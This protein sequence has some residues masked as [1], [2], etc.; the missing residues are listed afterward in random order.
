MR[1]GFSIRWHQGDAEG[2]TD[3]IPLDWFAIEGPGSEQSHMVTGPRGGKY[4]LARCNVIVRALEADLDYTAY[5]DLNS[6]ARSPMDI[7]TSRTS[8]KRE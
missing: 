6:R 7:G 3:L 5:E 1:A 4:G 8:R 2:Y